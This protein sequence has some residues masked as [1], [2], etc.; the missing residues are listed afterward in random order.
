MTRL[1]WATVSDRFFEAG[2]DRGVL[3]VGNNIGVPWLGLTQ[4][5]DS[6]SGGEAKSRY[7]DGVKISN[8]ASPEEFEADLEALHYPPEFEP[9]DGTVVVQN[10]L[11]V[12]QQTRKAFGLTY[13]TMVG[14]AVTG[15][16]HA[17]KIHILYN[18][19]A[20][21]S[22]R[23]YQ[24]LGDKNEAMPFSW[25]LTS[26][27]ELVEGLRPVSHFSVDTRDVPAELVD[28]LENMLY[29]DEFGDAHLPS[30]GELIFLFDAFEDDVYDAGSPFTPVYAIYDAGSPG[31]AVTL[32]LDGGAL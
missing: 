24:T 5:S 31:T 16:D 21:P 8:H 32:T 19:R 28:I 20:A 17:Y 2:V 10:G 30:P 26:R 12:S 13:R 3:Y 27:G 23:D 11:R 1:D 4:V 7:L 15:V 18:L 6:S 22:G 14:N 25:A 29:G 9:C